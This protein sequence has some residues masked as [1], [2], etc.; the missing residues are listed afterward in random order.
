MKGH[1]GANRIVVSMTLRLLDNSRLMCYFPNTC[2]LDSYTDFN[3]R[4]FRKDGNIL[5][6][7]EQG[8]KGDRKEQLKR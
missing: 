2:T 3:K 7:R 4:C 8:K 1:L 5:C 6:F